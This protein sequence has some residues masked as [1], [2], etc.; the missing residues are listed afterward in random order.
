MPHDIRLIP[1]PVPTYRVPVKYRF[2]P[3]LS[4]DSWEIQVPDPAGLGRSLKRI[5]KARRNRAER[6]QL[7]GN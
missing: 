1:P 6:G 7:E 5:E 4:D 3:P 2:V